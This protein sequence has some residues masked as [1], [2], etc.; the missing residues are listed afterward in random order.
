GPH[1]SR[2]REALDGDAARPAG[3]GGPPR[4]RSRDR[5]REL[6]RLDAAR[7]VARARRLLGSDP[8]PRGPAREDRIRDGHPRAGRREA[9]RSAG[10][11]PPRPSARDV[12]ARIYA[13]TSSSAP[14]ATS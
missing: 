12:A 11:R 9:L 5:L 7:R 3:G 1:V 14:F 4:G 2:D 6:E 8:D 10:A 13:V